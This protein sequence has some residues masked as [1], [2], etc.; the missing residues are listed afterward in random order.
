MHVTPFKIVEAKS[1]G[2]LDT[3]KK[4]FAEYARSLEFDLCFQDFEHELDSLPGEY[5]PPSGT[6]LLAVGRGGAYGCVALRR[7]DES[8][9]EMKRLYVRPDFRHRGIGRSL[10]ERVISIAREMGYR[11]MKLDTVSA[12]VEANKL[13]RELGFVATKPYRFNPLDSCLFLEL[14]L[15]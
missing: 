15:D 7:I 1:D 13:Y 6:L 14:R 9:C 12:M 10:A 2:E 3:V 11:S 8:T 4:L 5:S